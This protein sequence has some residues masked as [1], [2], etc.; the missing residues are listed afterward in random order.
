MR[1]I[2]VLGAGGFVGQSLIESFVLEERRGVRAIIRGH[3]NAASLCRFGS[4]IDLSLADAEDAS[5]LKRAFADIDTVVNLVTGPPATIV[6][7]TRALVEACSAAGVSRLVHLSS[8]VVYGDVLTKPRSDD[9][10]LVRGHWMPYA[11]AKAAS[12]V[13]LR[14]LDASNLDLVVLRPGIVWGVQ[15]P[16]TIAIA[17]QLS[18]KAAFLVDDGRGIFNGIFVA[19]LIGCLRRCCESDGR[20]GGFYNVGDDE[21]VTWRD[22]Y[23]ALGPALDCD[24]SRL[25]VVDGRKFPHSAGS[26]V[27]AIQS[28][29]PVNRL[30][31][32]LKPHVPDGWKAAIR[33]RLEGD[34]Q[35][36]RRPRTYSTRPSVDREM[37][38]LQRV[39]YKL[40]T[41]KFVDTFHFRTPVTFH[42]AI[43]RTIA[44]LESVGLVS[45]T[46]RCAL[47]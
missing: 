29:R 28:L 36:E 33:A 47:D 6:R 25:P 39:K 27:E 31:H 38:H 5:A 16:H 21:T 13:W 20:V 37:W 30:Y 1:S 46:F 43:R 2:A 44:W 22:F 12:E 41:K 8:A 3:R 18:R 7:S 19:N 23:D 11:R 9:D 24:P 32:Q 10:P 17:Q 34:Y 26:M 15:S 40:P 35:Y 45:E 14:S 42:E 4:A